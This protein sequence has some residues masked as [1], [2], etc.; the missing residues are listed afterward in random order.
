M[1]EL[2]QHLSHQLREHLESRRAV[3]WYDPRREFEPFLL[4]VCGVTQPPPPAGEPVLECNI[5][6][7]AARL[8]WFDGSL[9]AIRAAVEPLVACDQ[10]LPL[11]VYLPGVERDGKGSLLMELEKAG[12]CLEGKRLKSEARTVLRRAHSE[13]TID[14]MLA[15]EGLTYKDIVA[16]IEQGGGE[17]PSLLKVLFP[18]LQAP[19]DLL[20]AW[21]AGEEHDRLV[22]EK[23]AEYELMALVR[24]RLG[25]D[26]VDQTALPE[27]RVRTG[28]FIL[29]AEFRSDLQG[30][31]PV[32]IS[33][34][35]VPATKEQLECARSTA[36]QLRRRFAQAYALLA[37]QVEDEL[38]LRQANIPPERLGSIDTFRF[39]EKALIG[40]CDGLIASGRDGDALRII[41]ERQRSFWVD[42]DVRRQAQWEASRRMAELGIAVAAVSRA[43]E[44]AA[45]LP[46]GWVEAYVGKDGWFHLDQAQRR[47]EAWVATMDDDPEAERALA[48]VR[49]DCEHL[50]RK[51]ATQFSAVLE[52]ASWHV[53]GALPQ[54]RIYPDY[55]GSQ[56][57]IVAF[58]IVDSLR[59]EMGEELARLFG[60]ADDLR[61][62]P[63][64][65]ALPSITPVGMAALL[66]GASASF[67]LVE[68]QGKLAA[69]IDATPLPSLQA[70]MKLVKARVPGTTDIE[71]G[72]VLQA[73]SR[74]L[75]N[76]IKDA[77][78][79]VVRSQELDALGE[80]SA[81]LARQLMDT[82]VANVHRAVRKLA[83]AGI[84]QFVITADHGHQ[85]SLEKGDD[86][87]IDAPAGQLIEAHR[88]CWI[89]RGGGTPAGTRR[90]TGP[91]LGY[92]TDLEFVF[93]TGLGVFRS[94]GGLAYHHGGLSLQEI[95]IPVL[96]LRL[97]RQAKPAGAKVELRLGDVPTVLAN[98]T[99]GF[100]LLFDDMFATDPIVVRPALVAEGQQVGSAGMAVDAELDR[101]S[102]CV[103]LRPNKK[104]SVGMLLTREDCKKVRLVI[105]DPTTDAVLAQ[106]DEITVKL[107]G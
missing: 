15:P 92:D 47:L 41:A 101:A 72:T 69:R 65:A 96:S 67:S 48:R 82:V 10:P 17:R 14:E 91:E 4:D 79:V 104:A 78:L 24:T 45:E 25:L 102:A 97:P 86:M 100:S 39:E 57:D 1:H 53:E 64:I 70:R 34:I 9:F 58:F 40:Y 76:H 33:M 54:A 84:E 52:K 7:L 18:G 60:D 98:R 37:D 36:I 46:A 89:G 75:E 106:S 31:P 22:H 2:H 28:R 107:G 59:Y 93:P 73:S 77:R 19:A 29:T 6:G 11:V 32:E 87:K 68:H 23:G 20:A 71:L 43:I 35:P 51:M 13:G 81:F 99:F 88:R 49:S 3:V 55:V 5:A 50:L 21:L 16:L 38:G 56:K 74:R 90:I 30:E 85:F 103:T 12:K 63:A 8:V 95:V 62:R 27:A 61:L 94:G 42:S 105:Q 26:L 80:G 66:P 83:A 44:A